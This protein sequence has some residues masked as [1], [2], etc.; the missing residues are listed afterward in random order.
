[1]V[2]LAPP[3]LVT[4]LAYTI[5]KNLLGRTK[6]STWPRVARQLDKADLVYSVVTRVYYTISARLAPIE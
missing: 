2:P 5:M 4:P 1:L 3:N 6:L